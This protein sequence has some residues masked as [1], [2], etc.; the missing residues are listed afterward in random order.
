MYIRSSFRLLC[1]RKYKCINY[2]LYYQIFFPV[3]GE[4][5]AFTQNDIT[6]FQGNEVIKNRYYQVIDKLLLN[7]NI[8]R[9]NEYNQA[10]LYYGISI[11]EDK[12]SM[13]I[14]IRDSLQQIF[15]HETNY[16]NLFRYFIS[17]GMIY[18]I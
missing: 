17:S 16:V 1:Q 4:L 13:L 11:N 6:Q 5:P 15:P 7:M 12:M 8:T 9:I 10:E 2:T 3:L 18:L 14:R